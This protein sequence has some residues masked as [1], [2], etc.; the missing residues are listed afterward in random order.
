MVISFAAG[1]IVGVIGLIGTMYVLAE[2]QRR[3]HWK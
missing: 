2:L 3:G 1:V